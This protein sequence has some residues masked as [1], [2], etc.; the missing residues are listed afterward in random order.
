M[1][2]PNIERDG[3][4]RVED[5]DIGP[6]YEKGRVA[7]NSSILSWQKCCELEAFIH[8]PDVVSYCQDDAHEGQEAKNLNGF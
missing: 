1:L 5:D 4:Q 2:L 6:E 8:F 7:S 3:H